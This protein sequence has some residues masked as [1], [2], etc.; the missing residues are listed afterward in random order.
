MVLRGHQF[1]IVSRSEWF[2]FGNHMVDTDHH[3]AG[4]GD[5][6]FFMTTAFSYPPIFDCKIRLLF[7]LDRCKSTLNIISFR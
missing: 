2:L 4:D 7:T 1:L 5:N 3:H 6:G